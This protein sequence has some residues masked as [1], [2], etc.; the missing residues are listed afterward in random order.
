VKRLRTG[1]ERRWTRL[2]RGTRL[3][4]VPLAAALL[5]LAVVAIRGVVQEASAQGT[6]QQTVTPIYVPSTSGGPL[7]QPPVITS[8]HGVLKATDTAIRAGLPGSG[9]S[10]LRG[11]LPVY[12]SPLVP[13]TSPQPSP[14][15]GG[16]PGAPPHFPLNFAAAVQLTA[17]G[18][19]YPAQFP[20]PTLR[21][22][23]GDTLDLTTINKLQIG[24][25][26]YK[27]P[28][29][30]AEM[31]LHTHGLTTSPLDDGDNIYRTMAPNTSSQSVIKITDADGSGVDWYHTHKH[32]YV[33]DQVYS[34][35]AGML[36]VGDPLDPW[37]QYMGKYQEKLLGLTNGIVLSDA[38]GSMPVPA[39]ECPQGQGYLED[40]SPGAPFSGK[41]PNPYGEAW[42]DYVNGQYNPTI[43]VRPGETQIWTFAS[44]GRNTNFNLGITDRNLQNPWSATI[45][46]YEG[47][48]KDVQPKQITTGL[49]I[50]YQYNGPT[51]LDPGARITMAVTAP[52]TPGTY[53]LVNNQTMQNVPQ[54]QPFALATIQVAGA[55]ATVAPP[56]FTPTGPVPDV[57]RAKPDHLRT[58]TWTNVTSGKTIAFGING[59]FFPMNP[60]VTLQAGQVERWLLV[61]QSPVDHAFHLHQNHFAV[62]AVHSGPSGYTNPFVL[63]T[64]YTYRYASLRDTINIPPDGSVLIQFRVSK[65]LGK[66]VFHCHIL[67]HEDAG[68]MMGVLAIPSP[69][70]RRIALGTRPGQPST[71]FVKNGK[72]R[73][74]GRIKPSRGARGGVVTATGQLNNDPNDLTE[75]VVAGTRPN[76]RS[77]AMVSVYDGK[78][79]RRI[80]RFRP[81][82]DF[83]RAG[84]SVA[85]GNIAG[86]QADIIVGRVGPG[87]SLVRIFSASGRLLRTIKGTIPGPLPS[88][89]TVASAD[90]NGDNYDDV[91]IGAGRGG[92]RLPRVV[93]LNGYTLL[94][95]SQRPQRLFSFVAAGG[96]GSGVNLAAGYYD[97][98]TRPGLL[99][100][101]ITTP[102]TGRMAGTVQVW[103]PPFEAPHVTPALIGDPTVPGASPGLAARAATDGLR[104]GGAW[105][106]SSDLL[107]YCLHHFSGQASPQ[108]AS[109]ARRLGLPATDL[110]VPRVIAT[111]HPFGRHLSTGLNIAVT[112]L[113]TSALDAVAS[114]TNPNHAV[115]T[116]I[117]SAGAVSTIR[118]PTP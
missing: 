108:F 59:G 93:V 54:A 102:Q 66:Y 51:V 85:T 117:D 36:Q 47:F 27:L 49:Q 48:G 28:A 76:G 89:V 29:L 96:S 70:D 5:A 50:P 90:L 8:R 86:P 83:P 118:T 31:N 78:T 43:T 1:A 46:S 107:L 41:P 98:R 109:L 58:F 21:L 74:V 24:K 63:P 32:G 88:G 61:N 68:M 44:I 25:L 92:S 9:R 37:P 30:A 64:G 91:A 45:L 42:Q 111:L 39:N 22:N 26:N 18:T 56:K 99:A 62:L 13:P 115:Y 53:Y 97:P 67:P 73:S 110:N 15:P 19:T 7:Q 34:G 87:P 38:C 114:W 2:G 100:N 75:D 4:L 106:Q 52:S 35:L 6:P 71:V 12:S 104:H 84:V 10:V 81:F 14:Y 55:P 65:E 101:L 33:S 116:S 40:P 11:G 20:G 113:G 79:L 3:T 23:P 57:Y 112:H 82:P 95:R 60:I 16:P 80:A 77:P 72:G 17:Y 94:N 69:F 105:S 103:V